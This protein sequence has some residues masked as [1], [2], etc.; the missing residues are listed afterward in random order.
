MLFGRRLVVRSNLFAR[1]STGRLTVRAKLFGGFGV[2][3]VLLLVVSALAFTSLGSLS[4]TTSA[5]TRA[6]TL[7][8]QIRSMEIALR[9][10]QAIEYEALVVGYTDT[11]RDQL[12]AVFEKNGGNSFRE[13]LAEAR[14]L[15]TD[16]M[17]EPLDKAEE[18]AKAVE[19]SIKKTLELAGTDIGGA[20]NNRLQ[21]TQPAFNQFLEV[22][23]TL[24]TQAAKLAS[25]AQ[26][27]AGATTAR[28]RTLVVVIGLI[29]I[30]IATLLALVIS[31]ALV[32]RIKQLREA[33]D[34]IGEGDLTVNVGDTHSRDE[35]GDMAASFHTMVTRLR[36]TVGSFSS[37]ATELGAASQEMATTSQ[38][39]GRT[40]AE[41]AN[42]VSEVARDAGN[43]V[44]L[45][46]TFSAMTEEM[47]SAARGA[48]ENAKQTAEAAEQARAVSQDG[49][50]T[51]THASASMEAVREAAEAANETIR[52]LGSKSEE[53]GGI[54]ATITGIAGQTNLLALN[55]AIEAARAGEQGRGFAVVA[56]EVRKLAEESQ[57]AAANI[58]KLIQEIQGE[59]QKA[60]SVVEDGARRTQE[61]VSTVEQARDAF[62]R[63]GGSVDDV[64][65][66]IE[67]IAASVEQISA[68]SDR[69]KERMTGAAADA[70]EALA[71]TQQVAGS[72]QETAASTQQIASS[73]QELA[74][75]AEELERL[76]GQFRFEA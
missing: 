42:A 19:A 59:T 7:G 13:S 48:A 33:A 62:L 3:V 10:A 36:R 4:S 64:N 71:T 14:K 74:R 1:F 72:T 56:E 65:A 5:A 66:R 52:E 45:A 6:A 47:A 43:R 9:Q 41:I 49:V 58:G 2:A 37:T 32:S 11:L 38:E 73:A 34:R 69:M 39:A 23:G 76:V 25:E 35:L 68:S 63:I 24:Q 16:A 22:N 29:A 55:A 61:G 28:T 21:V 51:V 30:A 50:A 57:S 60:V 67:Q 15:R 44:E 54:V 17:A 20:A 27:D 53:I 26:D 40:V 12:A 31:R 46:Q 8:N 70:E 75:T 18:H